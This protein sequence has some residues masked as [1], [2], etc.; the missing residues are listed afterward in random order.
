MNI[1]L[2]KNLIGEKIVRLFLIVYLFS[3]HT[4]CKET[5]D[6]MG[7][8]ERLF[9][10]KELQSKSK[11][12]FIDVSNLEKTSEMLDED[13]YWEIIDKSLKN[14]SNQ[15]EQE[16]YL[17]AELNKL[18]LK[19][20]IG[21]NLRTEE[22]HSDTYTSEMWCSAYVLRRGCGDDSF[23]YFRYWLISRGKNAYYKTKNNPDDLIEFVIEGEED[24][25][26][27]SF[28]LIPLTVFEEKTGKELYDFVEYKLDNKESRR[29]DIQFNWQEEDPLS[30]QKICPKLFEKFWN[31]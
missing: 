10:N 11:L 19:Q 25:D 31:K 5:E 20:I 8:F 27:E 4:N 13:L 18:T 26:F 30:M 2:L 22:L 12:S 21:F 1:N 9:G 14:T 28:S 17:T 24:Y 29:F 7:F 15:N 23:D 6:N 3:I 16:K